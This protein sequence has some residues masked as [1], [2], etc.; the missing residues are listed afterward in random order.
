MNR[1]TSVC[2]WERSCLAPHLFTTSDGTDENAPSMFFL[3]RVHPRQ[4]ALGRRVA[5]AE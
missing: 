1:A 5:L 3:L 4:V 2:G